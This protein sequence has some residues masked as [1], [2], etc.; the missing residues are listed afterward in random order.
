MENYSGNPSLLGRQERSKDRSIDVPSR[1]K[2]KSLLN[3]G[4]CTYEKEGGRGRER[5]EEEPFFSLSRG[6]GGEV[7]RRRRGRRKKKK[8]SKGKRGEFDSRRREE[9]NGRR[10]FLPFFSSFCGEKGGKTCVCIQQER[11]KKV[12]SFGLDSTLCCGRGEEGGGGGLDRSFP[13]KKRGEIF[14]SSS[15]SFLR[16]NKKSLGTSCCISTLCPLLA[17]IRAEKREREKKRVPSSLSFPVH[18][19][20]HLRRER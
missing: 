8:G 1:G 14:S 9:E 13:H 12:L 20:P 6:G 5:S 19:R 18:K 4:G 3:R 2:K 7:E 10:N 15:S 16:A 17:F 11:R